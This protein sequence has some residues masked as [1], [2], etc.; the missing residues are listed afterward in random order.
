M[1]NNFKKKNPYILQ[2]NFV[3]IFIKNS[4]SKGVHYKFWNALKHRCYLSCTMSLVLVESGNMDLEN[5][6]VVIQK[7]GPHCV[8]LTVSKK[9]NLWVYHRG[10]CRKNKTS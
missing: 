2:L 4:S 6:N 9:E 3:Y 10:L 8:I 5:H 7:I 1:V